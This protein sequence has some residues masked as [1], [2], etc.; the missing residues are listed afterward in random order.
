MV[1]F[2][3]ANGLAAEI[4]FL[5]TD[6]VTTVVIPFDPPIYVKSEIPVDIISAEIVTTLSGYDLGNVTLSPHWVVNQYI[7]LE[8]QGY[9]YVSGAKT[10][11]IVYKDT[12]SGSIDINI[13]INQTW[14]PL[15]TIQQTGDGTT[16]EITI[17]L[18]NHF[19]ALA[20]HVHNA[21][22]TIISLE[23]L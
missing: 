19:V 1:Q 9:I 16:K 7:T 4:P 3:S 12:F 8:S 21:P 10:L 18:S 17:S 11:K 5:H 2:W 14:V 23:L 22:F 20:L 13:L 6:S 15:T